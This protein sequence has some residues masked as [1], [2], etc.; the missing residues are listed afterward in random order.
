MYGFALGSSMADVSL[1]GEPGP[2]CHT[3]PRDL[4]AGKALEFACQT[5]GA[6]AGSPCVRRTVAG[7]VVKVLPH[8][9]RG[10]SKH[11]VDARANRY[12]T[13]KQRVALQR[14]AASLPT[15]SLRAW[16]E[17]KSIET[18]F[19]ARAIYRAIHGRRSEGA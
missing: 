12:L 10:P 8:F 17:R 16:V 19:S 18:G 11:V 6:E 13:A 2:K 4:S 15:G 14:E 1:F 3:R 9:G 5:C 7:T